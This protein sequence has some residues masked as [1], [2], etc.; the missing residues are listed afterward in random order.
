MK[1]IKIYQQAWESRKSEKPGMTLL[2]AAF[3]KLELTIVIDV[4]FV[5]ARAWA[6]KGEAHFA[7]LR[8]LR[9][10]VPPEI[11]PVRALLPSAITNELPVIENN[12]CVRVMLAE[13]RVLARDFVDLRARAEYE[14][15]SFVDG[16]TT[17]SQRLLRRSRWRADAPIWLLLIYI[18]DCAFNHPISILALSSK[19]LISPSNC[20]YFFLFL[21]FSYRYS[22]YLIYGALD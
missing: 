15:I 11:I 9:R 6:Q 10:D 18:F 5:H 12:R 4:P 20:F 17:I 8:N 7:K 19:V 16:K 22:V 14:Y 13:D 2:T 1:D 3:I 21:S